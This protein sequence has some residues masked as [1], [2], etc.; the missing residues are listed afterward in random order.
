MFKHLHARKTIVL[1]KVTHSFKQLPTTRFPLDNLQA[2]S[3]PSPF[4]TFTDILF[5][6]DASSGIFDNPSSFWHSVQCSCH[7]INLSDLG[8]RN[9]HLLI[10][11][12]LSIPFKL[13]LFAFILSSFRVLVIVGFVVCLTTL[14]Q[15]HWLLMQY[16]VFV[17]QNCEPWVA[18]DI[19]IKLRLI[20][21]PGYSAEDRVEETTRYI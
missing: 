13:F 21:P 18:D 7:L 12:I 17:A 1:G 10:R 19:A 4:V 11:I 3:G 5:F 6:L 15:Q 16:R 20:V 14:L 9:L 2:Y 8:P